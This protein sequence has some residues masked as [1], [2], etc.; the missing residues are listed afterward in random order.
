LSKL[1][2]LKHKTM[3]K[4]KS[5]PNLPTTSK[6]KSPTMAKPAVKAA[7]KPVAKTMIKKKY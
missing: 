2:K 5:T 3:A 7:K 6:M 1:K 4:P